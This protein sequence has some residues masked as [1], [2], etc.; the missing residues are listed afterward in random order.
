[1]R[2]ILKRKFADVDDSACYSS[3][4]S[5]PPSSLSSPGS[6]EWE[7]DGESGDDH[8]FT[9]HSP[10]SATLAGTQSSV[11]FDQVTV[12]SFPRCQG[13]TSVPSRG[14]ATLGMRQRH[15]TLQR[16]T[17]AEHALERRHRRRERLRVR[18]REERLQTLKHRLIT[19]G[20]VDQREADTLT[21]DQIPDDD[22]HISDAD[23]EDG[24]FL[25][26]YSSR[27]R[28]A[29]LQAAGV[30]RIDREEKKQLHALRF[31]REACGCDCRGFCEPETC[32]CSLAGIKCQVDRLSFPCG[33]T[34]DG[35]GNTRGRVEFNS[36]RVR[37]HY[38]HT[39]MRL[40]LER[41]LQDETRG[42]ED[43][44]PLPGALQEHG[45]SLTVPA[46]LSL[47]FIPERPVAEENSCSSD[48]TDSSCSSSGKKKSELKRIRINF[49]EV[50]LIPLRTLQSGLTDGTRS[51]GVFDV[52]ATRL[53]RSVHKMAVD[54]QPR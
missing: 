40:E 37:T 21:V 2:G 47:Q 18:L 45:L 19:S 43:Q 53:F 20:A 4:S 44:T 3:S 52:S 42:Q 6:S 31:S 36:R 25:Q 29:L 51:S 16:Y 22:V 8:D 50:A 10:S 1:M 49:S 27:Q 9:P 12:F 26:P 30:K 15:S 24:A 14:G 7:S 23:L 46:A 13:F 11:R 48:M 5:S 54:C 35:C 39:T 17:L 33:C 28:Q 34:K 32:A 41:R 38:I